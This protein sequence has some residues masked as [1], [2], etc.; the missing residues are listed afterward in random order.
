MPRTVTLIDRLRV[1]RLVWEPSQRL[2]ELPRGK[3][4]DYCREV[5]QNI[6]AAGCLWRVRVGRRPAIRPGHSPAC[7]DAR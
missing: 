5:R 1:E 7:R 6:L 3:R 4:A 2:G